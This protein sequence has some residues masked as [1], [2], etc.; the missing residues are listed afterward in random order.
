MTIHESQLANLRAFAKTNM[1]AVESFA[2]DLRAGKVEAI[3]V[4]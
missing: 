2:E 3:K 4:V 1:D